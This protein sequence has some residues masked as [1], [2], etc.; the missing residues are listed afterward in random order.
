MN[1]SELDRHVKAA[2]LDAANR[3][4]MPRFLPGKAIAA[5]YKA[6]G[7]AVTEA[8]RESEDILATHLARL[9]PGIGIVG[10][11][12]V[13]HDATQLDQLGSGA[14]WIIDPLDG[15]GN[16]AQG[17]QPFGMLI[18]LANAGI[19]IAGWIFDPTSGRLCSAHVNQGAFIDGERL[20]TEQSSPDIPIVAVTKLF[21]DA[22]SRNTAIAS[23]T[24]TC[25]VVDSPRCAADQY[26]RVAL[27]GND[28]TVFTRTIAW[29]H[30]AGVVF[31]N[32]AGGMAACLD[33]TPYRCD[34][35]DNGLIIAK[36]AAVWTHVVNALNSGN[37][38]LKG[39]HLT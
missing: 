28:A 6:V 10:E 21:A 35:P 4:I 26:P 5:D 38:I 29:D 9:I 24:R 20:R 11:E 33:S 2:L 39:A 22:N 34:R 27:G 16:F 30:A 14:C 15:T 25:E 3:A 8:D 32:E 37:I 31:L 18:A 1:M 13:H 19:P 17:L 36:N 7:E 23:L 12:S